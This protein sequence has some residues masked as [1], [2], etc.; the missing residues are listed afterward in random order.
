[1]KTILITGAGTGFGN[2][3][4]MRLAEKGF[5]V[6]ASVEIYA[7]VQPLKRQA[8]A[9]G[10][11]LRVVKLDVTNEGDRKKALSWNVE[12]LV[13]NAGLLEGGSV[14]D[15]PGANM[16]NQFEVN[17]IGPLLLTQGIAKQ[18]AKRGQG[19]IV[20]V[21]SR[22]GVNVNPF[23]GI[24]AA[25]KHATEAIAQT[26]SLE[27]QEF[28]VE[29]A[30]VNPGPFL[31]GFNDRGFQTWESWLDDPTDRLFDYSK[32][33]FP[34]AQFDPEPVYATLTAVAAGEVDTFRNLE[35]KSML[36][37]TKRNIENVWTKKI[38]D[39]LGTR[40]A[41]LQASFDMKPETPVKKA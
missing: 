5:D 8:T 2:E 39:G 13:N 21:S 9:R 18:M 7:Q 31:T 11:N 34:R 14:V 32:L 10:V 20:W 4:A 3:A 25:S 1:M 40:P 29:V 16:R 17:V 15:I 26:M 27:L 6:I 12:I 23:T 30:T 38:K 37:E 41:A 28:G 36:D 22:E 35:P 24:Y 19:R 33:A